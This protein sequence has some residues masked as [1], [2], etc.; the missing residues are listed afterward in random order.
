[1][2]FLLTESAGAL[3]VA[4]L[5]P[6]T[7]LLACLEV[8]KLVECQIILSRKVLPVWLGAVLAGELVVDALEERWVS[9]TANTLT[10]LQSTPHLNHIADLMTDVGT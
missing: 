3:L 10:D 6:Y 8:H 7:T 4:F 5:L 9:C 2:T 1:M